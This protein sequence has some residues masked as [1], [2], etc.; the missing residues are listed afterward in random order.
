[1]NSKPI[2]GALFGLLLAV[3]LGVGAT[4]IH[5]SV[6]AAETSKAADCDVSHCPASACP[7][8]KAAQI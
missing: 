6:Q 3:G 5:A 2:L 8:S 4:Q 7:T 1:M